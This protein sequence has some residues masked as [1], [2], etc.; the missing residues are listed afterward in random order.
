MT[1]PPNAHIYLGLAFLAFA[2]LL[3]VASRGKKGAP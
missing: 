2:L 3:A 1:I